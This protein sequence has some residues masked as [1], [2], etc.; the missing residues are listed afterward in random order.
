AA[1]FLERSAAL[2][3][4]PERRVERVLAAAQAKLAAGAFDVAAEL[5]TT[6]ETAP[7]D[8]GQR[9]RLDL[10]RGRISFATHRGGEGATAHVLRAARRLTVSD[11]EWSRACYLDALEMGILTGDMDPAV[12][13]AQTAPPAPRPPDSSDLV[14]DG[15]VRLAA[16]GHRAAVPLLGPIVADVRN[17]VWVRRPSLA[18]LLA[19][20]VWDFEAYAGTAEHLVA[21]GRESG[22]FHILP[23]GLA[24]LATVSAHAG[25]FGAAM[26]QISEGEAIADATGASPLVYPRLHL[27]A[28]RGR[29]QEAVELFESVLA[30]SQR[31][32]LSVHWAT[33][34]LNNGLGDYPAA[35][36][37]AR[38][39]VELDD[40]AMTGL[41]LPELVES[42]VRSGERELA[43]SA[44]GSLA[45]RTRAGGTPWGLG[46]E[47]Y[48][49][50][51]VTGDEDA[52]RE[53]VDHLDGSRAAVYR[54][55]AHLLY[56]EWLRREGRRRDARERLRQAHGLFA[57]MGTEAFA[58]RAAGEL[59]ATG[60]HARS[61]SAP[62]GEQLTMQ[63][64]HIARLVA[65][66]ETSK[67][68][69]AKLFLSPRTVDAHLRNIFRKLGLTS[70]KQLRDLPGIR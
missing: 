67:E 1:A 52:Y 23:I 63:E 43:A 4:D 50:A 8:Q 62:V 32:S 45:E 24:M 25:D 5:L 7:L 69:A 22:S 12:A 44:L 39:A 49:R 53:A 13:A 20:E 34:V 47:A 70:R 31:M 6:A 37:A 29:R 58:D 21:V 48:S 40:L 15:L 35:L 26:E 19:V 33:A 30:A 27:A 38:R 54:A 57:D 2:T 10:L 18:V 36:E 3:L 55:R 46:V 66:G 65:E 17:E 14:L 61:R 16:E 68:V 60:E 56:G 41:A 28:L 59:R 9:A 51:L 42:A 11:P 64:V